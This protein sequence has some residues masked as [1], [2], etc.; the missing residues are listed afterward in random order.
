MAIIKFKNNPV[1][2]QKI[3]NCMSNDEIS[4]IASVKDLLHTSD[5]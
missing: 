5:D 1:L 2:N 3:I 4:V